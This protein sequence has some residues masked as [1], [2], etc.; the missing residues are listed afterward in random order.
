MIIDSLLFLGIGHLL[1]DFYFQSEKMSKLKDEN[2]RDV[3][4]HS[5]V[6][7]LVFFVLTLPI[8][9]IDMVHAATYAALF[10]FLID[11]FK[12]MLLKKKK[13]RKGCRLFV[14]DQCLHMIS[15]FALAYGMYCCNYS[16]GQIGF[17]QGMLNAFHCNAETLARWGLALLFVHVPSN[18]FIQNFLEFYKPKNKDAIIRSDNKAGRRIGTMERLIMLAFLSKD[19]YVAIGFVLTAKSI[20][21][22]D[23]ITKDEK[24]AEYY[25][26][27]TLVSTL[28]VIICR[29]LIL[30]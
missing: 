23:K 8:F 28:C 30:P 6:Y 15:I 13:I 22:Y 25:L 24:F 20:A 9:S 4:L 3:F 21:R 11:S 12:Y 2:Y 16:I 26:L 14:V 29:M 18:I 19:Q 1:G 17:V 27:G 7:Y 10:H 5:Y